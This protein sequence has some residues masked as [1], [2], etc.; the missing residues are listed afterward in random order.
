MKRRWT[1]LFYLALAMLI[2]MSWLASKFGMGM[3]QLMNVGLAGAIAAAIVAFVAMVN[4]IDSKWPAVVVVICSLPFAADAVRLLPDIVL[5]V[6]YFGPSA[7]VVVFGNLATIA[8]GLAVLIA[9][10]PPPQEPPPVAPA[11]IV[12]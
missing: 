9:R 11:R 10:R 4:N 3:M 5:V 1:I 6:E 8:F 12:D 7:L 2:G